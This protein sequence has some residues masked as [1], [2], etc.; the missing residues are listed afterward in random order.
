MN[1]ILLPNGLTLIFLESKSG[2]IESSLIIPV[3]ELDET[4]EY[5]E[6]AHICEH[7]V[8]AL[9]PGFSQPY[10]FKKL[11][12]NGALFTANTLEDHTQ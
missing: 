6:C 4:D 10:G 8:S 11:I 9:N 1:Q 5:S 2:P 7:F 12:G 3:G